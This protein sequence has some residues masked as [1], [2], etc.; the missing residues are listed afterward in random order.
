M[1]RTFLRVIALSSVLVHLWSGCGRCCVIETHHHHMDVASPEAIVP[2]SSDHEC[3]HG[4]CHEPLHAARATESEPC[5]TPCDGSDDSCDCCTCVFT[6]PGTSDGSGSVPSEFLQPAILPAPVSLT[7]PTEPVLS[8][9]FS[10]PAPEDLVSDA[11]SLRAQIEV[12][13]L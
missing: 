1:N 12:F 9:A 8:S 11:R 4:H 13:L 7:I 3:S 6:I 10:I 5:Q 2:S